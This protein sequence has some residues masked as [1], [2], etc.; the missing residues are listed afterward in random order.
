ML[1][2]TRFHAGLRDSSID[3]TFRRWSKAQ[4]KVG[5]AYRFDRGPGALVVDSIDKVPVGKITIR[6][7]K[8]AGFESMEDLKTALRAGGLERHSPDTGVPDRLSLRA[9]RSPAAMT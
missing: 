5:G 6:E 4:A 1:F 7:V 2:K 8:R 9:D 3:L